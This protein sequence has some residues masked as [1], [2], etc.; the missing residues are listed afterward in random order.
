[1]D[2]DSGADLVRRHP[3]PLR[4]LRCRIRGAKLELEV[5]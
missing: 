2:P 1:M 5:F 3:N 4:F